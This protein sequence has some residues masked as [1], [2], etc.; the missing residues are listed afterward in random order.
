MLIPPHEIPITLQEDLHNLNLMVRLKK[1]E[2]ILEEGMKYVEERLAHAT[3]ELLLF[4][5]MLIDSPTD[6]EVWNTYLWE[7][8]MKYSRMVSK[9]CK[10]KTE[11]AEEK[12]RRDNEEEITLQK[13]EDFG[14]ISVLVDM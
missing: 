11:I 10:I 7:S 1:E 9:C 2:A 6:D 14:R 13:L 12:I 3:Y 4:R 8:I 5:N